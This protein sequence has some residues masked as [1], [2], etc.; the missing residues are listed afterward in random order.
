MTDG[1]IDTN[2]IAEQNRRHEKALTADYE[3]LGEQLGRRKIDIE[4][5]TR[6]VAAFAVALPSWGVGT[7]GTR[8]AR[9][10]GPGEPRDV[11]DKLDDCAVIQQLTR[12]TPTV[13]LHIPWDKVKDL[14]RD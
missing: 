14:R 4:K 11:F 1:P 5:V 8:F 10:P 6:A 7:G 13:S 9:Y 2:L 3:T 12:A